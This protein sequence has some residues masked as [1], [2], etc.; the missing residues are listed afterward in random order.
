MSP[1]APWNKTAVGSTFGHKWLNLPLKTKLHSVNSALGSDETGL[2]F[3]RSCSHFCQ[4]GELDAWLND[5]TDSESSNSFYETLQYI[6]SVLIPKAFTDKSL[7]QSTSHFVWCRA[8]QMSPHWAYFIIRLHFMSI[9]REMMVIKN[10]WWVEG[11]SDYLTYS[12]FA[13]L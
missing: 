4:L 13:Y 6:I 11:S 3:E 9:C 12:S 8:A 2:L 10:V 1:A 7:Q 5:F